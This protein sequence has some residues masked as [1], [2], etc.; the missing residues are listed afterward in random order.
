MVLAYG[1][2]PKKCSRTRFHLRGGYLYTV[3]CVCY[4]PRGAGS[5]NND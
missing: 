4:P 5:F 3:Y 2:V 1:T